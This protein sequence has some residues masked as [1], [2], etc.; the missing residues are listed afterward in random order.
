MFFENQGDLNFKIQPLSSRLQLSTLNAAV[1]IGL[2]DEENVNILL[3]GNFYE[4]NIEMGRYDS[5]YGNILS[6]GKN[7]KMQVD[8]IDGLNIK[9]QVRRIESIQI[10]GK[11]CYIILK[12]DDAPQILELLSA[13]RTQSSGSTPLD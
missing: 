4:N 2:P 9:G 12:N 13:S 10:S 8:G 1:V 11:Q 3:G 5:D 6:I 7:N